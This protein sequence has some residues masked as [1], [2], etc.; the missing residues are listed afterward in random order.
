M[1]KHLAICLLLVLTACNQSN[2]PKISVYETVGTSS[3]RVNEVAAILAKH[4]ALPTSLED[5]NFLEEQIGDGNLGQSDYR[6]F[7]FIQ[8]SPQEIAQWTQ[9]L[10][11]RPATPN[12]EMPSKSCPWWIS[13]EPF[14]SLQFYK[15]ETL[16]GRFNGW[17]G[18]SQDT[19][20]IYMFT[21]TM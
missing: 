10:I 21:F 1:L 20:R 8:V 6:D 12:Y 18:V 4:K 9:S 5:A 3:Q 17:I 16:T 13:E 19:G 7:Y 11:P 14:K 2:Q 15:P